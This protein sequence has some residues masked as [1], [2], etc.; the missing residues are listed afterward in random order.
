MVFVGKENACVVVVALSRKTMTLASKA[1]SVRKNRNQEMMLLFLN[2]VTLFTLLKTVLLKC[3]S[4]WH[5]VLY[6]IGGRGTAISQ[7]FSY[8]MYR[9]HRPTLAQRAY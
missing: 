4:N 5:G 7:T 9:N 8:D 3:T 2:C 1:L 6:R